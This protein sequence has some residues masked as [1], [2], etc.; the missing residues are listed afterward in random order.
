MSN[1]VIY[2]AFGRP[3][4]VMAHL[5]YL[6]LRKSNPTTPVTVVTNA[7]R[8]AAFDGWR[9]GTDTWVFAGD[10]DSRNRFYKT[11]ICEW[12]PYERSLFIDC[13]TLVVGNLNGMFKVLEHADIALMTKEEG[14]LNDAYG[15]IA[16]LGGEWTLSS[17]PHWNGGVSAFRKTPL[18]AAAD[19]RGHIL[20]LPRQPLQV[21]SRAA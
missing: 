16:I 19:D 18:L 12:S 10:D 14:L 21:T 7:C 8:T 4:L 20:E 1:G 15:N 17:L 9:E 2:V 11:S 6:T 5:S 13:D 3:Y